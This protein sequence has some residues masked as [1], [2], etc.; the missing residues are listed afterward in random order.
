[1]TGI[2]TANSNDGYI[3][4][5]WLIRAV[6]VRLW[7]YD[8]VGSGRLWYL[9]AVYVEDGLPYPDWPRWDGHPW[10]VGA[11]WNIVKHSWQAFWRRQPDRSGQPA[12][13]ENLWDDD[14]R[15]DGSKP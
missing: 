4:E 3:G 12:P 8:V 10:L 5:V 6:C 14:Y 11:L 2:E 7:R 9:W 1:M 15:P 13:S